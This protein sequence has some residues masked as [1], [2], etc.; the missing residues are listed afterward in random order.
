MLALDREDVWYIT[1]PVR[2]ATISESSTGL[3]AHLPCPL[4]SQ[5]DMALRFHKP[6][7]TYP[8]NP[9]AYLES[10]HS[11]AHRVPYLCP[12]GGHQ[13]L[14]ALRS[15]WKRERERE[16]KEK[17][18]EKKCQPSGMSSKYRRHLFCLEGRRGER[19]EY[20]FLSI[21]VMVREGR[22]LHVLSSTA[23]ATADLF[24][25]GERGD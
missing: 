6:P 14:G 16:R 24:P 19:G 17:R 15:R 3:T 10:L 9:S 21:K 7:C 2:M 13:K 12:G 25:L 5:T 22:D 1:H 4:L 8:R 18:R 20:N 11:D 23:R